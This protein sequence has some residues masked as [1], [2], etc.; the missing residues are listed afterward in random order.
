MNLK[1]IKY[2]VDRVNGVSMIAVKD[3]IELLLTIP[4]LIGSGIGIVTIIGNMI[5]KLEE[6]DND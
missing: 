1:D 5:R 6:L 3:V 2:R 4:K